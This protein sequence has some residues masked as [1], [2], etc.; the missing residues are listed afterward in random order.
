VDGRC[1]KNREKKERNTSVVK[2]LRS[3]IPESQTVQAQ[4]FTQKTFHPTL[5]KSLKT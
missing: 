2:L 4:K 3:S 5:T 1:Q